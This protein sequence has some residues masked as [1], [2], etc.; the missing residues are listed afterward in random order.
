MFS[1]WANSEDLT[2]SS[3]I[4]AAKEINH[5]LIDANLG[6]EGVKYLRL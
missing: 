1:K 6:E 5:G 2:D 4:R 3:L